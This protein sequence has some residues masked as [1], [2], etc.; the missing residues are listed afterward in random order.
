MQGKTNYKFSLN[1]IPT[2]ILLQMEA[3]QSFEDYYFGAASNSKVANS[4]KS[5]KLTQLS[6]AS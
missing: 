3:I 4:E 5:R 2:E 6:L 1:K